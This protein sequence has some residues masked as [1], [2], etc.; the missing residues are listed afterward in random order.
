MA[1]FVVKDSKSILDFFNAENGQKNTQYLRDGTISKRAK[2]GQF[3]IF[4][5]EVNEEN[6]YKWP[7]WKSNFKWPKPIQI[8]RFLRSN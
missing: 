1:Y 5:K 7:I 8:R 3:W 2:T 4:C 6:G